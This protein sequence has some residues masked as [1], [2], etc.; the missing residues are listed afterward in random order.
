MYCCRK[1]NPCITMLSASGQAA[2][3]LYLYLRYD[4]LVTL[5]PSQGTT[6]P[7]YARYTMPPPKLLCPPHGPW[8][9]SSPHLSADKQGQGSQAT[10]GLWRSA[11]LQIPWTAMLS[12][13][14]AQVRGRERGSSPWLVKSPLQHK[15]QCISLPLVLGVVDISYYVQMNSKASPPII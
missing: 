12:L 9:A 7:A 14:A 6:Y 13:P 15:A 2:I 11:A 4:V 1:P 8:A 10:H 5:R 3:Y